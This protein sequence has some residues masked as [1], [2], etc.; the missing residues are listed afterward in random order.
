MF[1]DP[2]IIATLKL[3]EKAS[4]PKEEKTQGLRIVHLFMAK[5]NRKIQGKRLRRTS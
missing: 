1:F 3:K 2:A 4:K 5:K